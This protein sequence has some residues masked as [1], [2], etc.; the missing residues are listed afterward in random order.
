MDTRE[1]EKKSV[2][3]IKYARGRN[4][5]RAFVETVMKP[6]GSIKFGEYLQ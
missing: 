1:M 6:L 5:L 4:M 3:W 2:D